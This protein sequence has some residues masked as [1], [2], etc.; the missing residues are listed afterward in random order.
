MKLQIPSFVIGV[1]ILAGCSGPTDLEGGKRKLTP[2]KDVAA[3][4]KSK[5]AGEGTIPEQGAVTKGLEAQAAG[6]QTAE[7]LPT[8]T[9]LVNFYPKLEFP[10]EAGMVTGSAG[11]VTSP[12]PSV[13]SLPPVA[14][15]TPA[16]AIAPGTVVMV[17][18]CQ[19]YECGHSCLTCGPHCFGDTFGSEDPA[20][21]LARNLRFC[22]ST[23]KAT[24]PGP[25]L[26]WFPGQ[27]GNY[28]CPAGTSK[29][30]AQITVPGACGTTRYECV[31]D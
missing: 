9:P 23:W 3:E 14:T 30:N 27:N 19:P 28:E 25:N 5:P 13:I 12:P 18:Q 1:L 24:W 21:C 6:T 26:A 16:T 8:S 29:R 11:T 31:K 4:A 17:N 10:S 7:P 2:Q 22:P 20:A 15:A